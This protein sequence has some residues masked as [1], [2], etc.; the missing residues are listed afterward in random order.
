MASDLCSELSWSRNSSSVF[1]T[2]PSNSKKSM[3]IVIKFNKKNLC[4]TN[5]WKSS[6]NFTCYSMRMVSLL[7]EKDS[8]VTI[9]HHQQT[10]SQLEI[11]SSLLIWEKK[12]SHPF[13][14]EV[15]CLTS[16][17]QKVILIRN[18]IFSSHSLTTKMNPR[19]QQN[20]LIEPE[21]QILHG[22]NSKKWQWARTS[23]NKTGSPDSQMKTKNYYL[24]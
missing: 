16:R 12:I 10:N 15:I 23:S 19:S 8:R 9:L 24:D 6:I 4:C 21:L 1:L 2:F 22:G 5:S 7:M 20:Y 3:Q 11:F 17:S 14:M 13:Q 18:Q